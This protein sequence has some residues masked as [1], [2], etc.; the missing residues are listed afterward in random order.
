MNRIV[1]VI[2]GT[3]VA[4]RAIADVVARCSD[5]DPLRVAAGVLLALMFTAAAVGFIRKGS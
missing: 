3:L 2:A 5:L 1:W 4:G